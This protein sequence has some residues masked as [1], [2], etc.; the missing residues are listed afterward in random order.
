MMKK[1]YPY[2]KNYRLYAILCPIMMILEVASDVLIPYVMGKLVDNGIRTGDMDIVVRMVMIM[3]ALAL[4]GM[5][6]GT[7]S[8]YFGAKAGYGAA[9]DIRRETY[10]K[11]QTFSFSNLDKISVPSLITRVTTDADLVGMVLMMSLRMAVRAPFM[12]ILGLFMALRLKPDLAMIYF[13][14]IPIIGFVIFLIMRKADPLFSAV[15]TKI[16]RINAVVQENLTGMR[17]VKAFNRQ[18]Y[19]TK[20]FKERNDDTFNTVIKAI[21]HVMLMTPALTITIMTG[22][23][24]VLYIG[25]NMVWSGSMTQ[26]NLV[27]FITY[28]GQILI[29]L[30]FMTIFLMNYT[31]GN[32]SA[33]RIYEVMTTESEIK[34]PENPIMEVKSGD[35]EFRNVSFSYDDGAE[36]VLKNINLKVKHGESLGIIGSTGSSKTSLV[37]LIPRLYDVTSGQVLVDGKDVRDYDI[38]SLRDKVAMVLQKNTLI[39]GSI[40][41][42]MKWGN[43]NAT[44]EEIIA[45]LKKAQAYEFVSKFTDGIDHVVDQGGTNYSGGQ[46]QRLTIARAMMTSPK[47]LIL[48]DSTSALDMETDRKLRAEIMKSHSDFTTIVIAQ[49]IDSIKDFDNIAVVENGEIESFGKHEELLKISKVYKEIYESQER[50]IGE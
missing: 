30:M 33:E 1:M 13:L 46:R 8:S 5:L 50:G 14:I 37:Q 22:M 23:I 29:S 39:S 34:N 4:F 45:A 47:I 12:M 38:K 20:K 18:D 11:I 27:S 44:D 17:V 24:L 42:N 16:D 25:G 3:I 9:S 41:S 6:M 31:R 7:V 10:R 15:Q 40:R 35:I 48:D 2:L 21:S 28:N 49:R 26:G 32:A 43:Q 19:E 36:M